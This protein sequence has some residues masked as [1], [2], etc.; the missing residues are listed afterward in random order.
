[1]YIY[2]MFKNDIRKNIQIPYVDLPK[3]DGHAVKAIC[4]NQITTMKIKTQEA[5]N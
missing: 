3:N 4:W 2:Q 1:M 5:V